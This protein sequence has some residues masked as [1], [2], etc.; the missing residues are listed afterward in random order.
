MS[1]TE[2]WVI[3]CHSGCVY[4]ID[5]RIPFSKQYRYVTNHLHLYVTNYYSSVQ[6]SVELL[7]YCLLCVLLLS[8]IMS[9]ELQL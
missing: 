7:S 4:E 1:I 3:C 5:M 6:F 2:E 8:M 9:P